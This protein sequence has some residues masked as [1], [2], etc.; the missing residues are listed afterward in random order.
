MDGRK[1]HLQEISTDEEDV[2]VRK[3]VKNQNL[4][5]QDLRAAEIGE[6]MSLLMAG[7]KRADGEDRLGHQ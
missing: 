1:P 6:L 3:G 2:L 7:S 5:N 4:L